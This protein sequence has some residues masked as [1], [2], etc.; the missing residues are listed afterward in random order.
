[1]KNKTL[2]ALMIGIVVFGAACQLTIV[3]FIASKLSFSI[4]LWIGVL[5]ALFCAWH[6][7]W[8]LEQ[9]LGYNAGDNKAATALAT[10]DFFIRYG[11]LIAVFVLLCVTPWAS[12]YSAFIGIMGW[13]VGAYLAPT[14]IKII[15]SK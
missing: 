2:Q 7:A 9:N 10:R 6:S 5:L 1:M 15:H 13:K 14:I 11:V 12:P 8:S 4:G 3:W